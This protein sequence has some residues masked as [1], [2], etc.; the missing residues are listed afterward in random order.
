MRAAAPRH[1]LVA[2]GTNW[3]SID[4]LIAAE[5]VPDP[6]VVYTFHFYQPYLFT[7]Q[8]AP[9]AP[10]PPRGL[11]G[12]PYP[13]SLRTISGLLAAAGATEPQGALLAYGLARWDARK[14]DGQISRAVRWAEHHGVPL[15][16]G[17]FGAYPPAAPRDD[18]LRWLRDVRELLE[19]HGVGWCVWS[20]DESLGLDRR[21]TESGG[22][23][24]NP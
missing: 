7:H 21:V 8:G 23:T 24:V 12:V 5:P 9:W 2:S 10:H 1:T 22:V 6:N 19:R 14:I 4:G 16:A 11:A 3:S 20:Y 15:W 17:E 13:S 18:R